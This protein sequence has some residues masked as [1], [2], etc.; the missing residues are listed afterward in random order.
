M[1]IWQWAFYKFTNILV[2][3][4][5]RVSFVVPGS[6]GA[7]LFFDYS[8]VTAV[9]YSG[10]RPVYSARLWG[11]IHPETQTSKR[12]RP[13][14][15][16]FSRAE[17]KPDLGQVILATYTIYIT[18]VYNNCKVILV[19]KFKFVFFCSLILWQYYLTCYTFMSFKTIMRSKI[20]VKY[21]DVITMR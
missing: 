11:V 10:F 2:W 17:L 7:S 20:S 4:D 6:G 12:T 16:F 9:L 1:R 18:S 8:P 19:F 13:Y 15:F 21:M 14:A 3:P 5:R